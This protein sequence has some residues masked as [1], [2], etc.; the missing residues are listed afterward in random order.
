MKISK[1]LLSLI[2]FAA[3]LSSAYAQDDKVISV[4][5]DATQM[6][7]YVQIGRAHV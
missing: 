7:L 1:I 3:M 2:V 5:T 4:E 6:L